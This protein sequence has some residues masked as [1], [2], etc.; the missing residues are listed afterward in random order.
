MAK[1]CTSTIVILKSVLA[2]MVLM[3]LEQ[4]EQKKNDHPTHMKVAK[5]KTG[6]YPDLGSP[7]IIKYLHV[8]DKILT[9]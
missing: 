4:S 6:N 1:L 3:T 8:L 7:M 2:A 5:M 9:E